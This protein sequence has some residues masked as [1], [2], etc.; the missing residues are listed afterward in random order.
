MKTKQQIIFNYRSLKRQADE[1]DQ[2][3]G[4]LDRSCVSRVNESIEILSAGWTGENARAF[5][6]KE[7][8]LR[9]RIVKRADLLRRTAEEIRNAA[10]AL[11]KA[12]M[13]AL[14]LAQRRDS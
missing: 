3:A 4:K 8:A 5:I 14:E 12:E 2:A 7:E 13:S 11:Y 6:Q 10:D 9:D 1:L